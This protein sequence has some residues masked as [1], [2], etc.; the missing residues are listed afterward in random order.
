MEEYFKCVVKVEIEDDKGKIKYRKQP[1]IVSAI[2]PTDAE[3]ELIKH[4]GTIDCEVVNIA[5]TNIVDIVK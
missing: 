1:Y 5:L 4:M 2:S 3:A